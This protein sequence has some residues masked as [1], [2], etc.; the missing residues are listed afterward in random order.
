MREG[1]FKTDVG[2]VNIYPSERRLWVAYIN[3]VYFDTYGCAPPNKLT[4]FNI[5]RNGDCLYSEYKIQGLTNKKY[6]YCA[7]YCLY[8][9]YLTRVLGIDFK[10]SYLKLYH[11][12]KQ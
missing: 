1:P 5:K 2:L 7:S 10:S 12:I 11:Q 6:S 3:D 8:I 4:E 9:I